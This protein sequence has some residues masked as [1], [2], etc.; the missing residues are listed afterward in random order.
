MPPLADTMCLVN[1]HQ[2]QPYALLNLVQHRQEIARYEPLRC[3][4]QQLHPAIERRLL[5]FHTFGRT[6]GTID[7]SS[8]NAVR[9]QTVH[10]VM[11]ERDQ[12]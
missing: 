12:R 11:H 6:E 10:L 5:P 1:R 4:V 2:R 9:S 3:H 8:G 7:K